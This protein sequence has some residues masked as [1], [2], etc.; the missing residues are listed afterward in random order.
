MSFRGRSHLNTITVST[1][2]CKQSAPLIA[3]VRDCSL[4]C[5]PIPQ[6]NR[7]RL[8]RAVAQQL[9]N[10]RIADEC[11]CVDRQIPSAIQT[12]A[13]GGRRRGH[14]R[15][16]RGGGPLIASSAPLTP[17]KP[18]YDYGGLWI[19]WWRKRAENC[20]AFPRGVSRIG[21]VDVAWIRRHCS[22]AARGRTACLI[23]RC[24]S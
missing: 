1:F 18:S 21:G 6:N 11:W 7:P 22:W 3:A 2:Y 4:T 5:A 9:L 24:A 19:L 12:R 15:A 13:R 8:T 17:D 20:A 16:H 23:D 10:M 14:C